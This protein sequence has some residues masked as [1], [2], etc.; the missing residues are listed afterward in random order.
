MSRF[1][2]IIKAQVNVRTCLVTFSMNIKRVL[3]LKII[4]FKIKIHLGRME[5]LSVASSDSESGMLKDHIK[6][7]WQ[8][9]FRTSNSL[10]Y[11]RKSI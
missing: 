1:M 11:M 4:I 10:K 9:D 8:P 6:Q 7:T 3:C 2:H 5:E